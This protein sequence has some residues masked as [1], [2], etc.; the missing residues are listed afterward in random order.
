MDDQPLEKSETAPLDS[1]DMLARELAPPPDVL[2]AMNKASDFDYDPPGKG[3]LTGIV[4]GLALLV[5][6]RV[7][8][9]G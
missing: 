8:L 7:G 1:A 5:F 2:P 4:V 3:C 6:P 9:T